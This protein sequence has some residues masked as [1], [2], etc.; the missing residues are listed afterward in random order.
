[1]PG[2]KRTGAK[3]PKGK[4]EKRESRR[5]RQC[6]KKFASRKKREREL[7]KYIRTSRG[8]IKRHLENLGAVKV[9]IKG[10]IIEAKQSGKPFVIYHAIDGVT[11]TEF[12]RK[13]N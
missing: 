1:M 8:N 5:Y 10:D 7:P 12:L 6:P 3:Q 13:D 11:S 2:R 4:F 9:N